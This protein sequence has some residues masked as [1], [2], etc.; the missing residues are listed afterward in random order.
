MNFETVSGTALE[1]TIRVSKPI[2]DAVDQIGQ[3]S[4]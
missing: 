1:K 2:E 3:I 4:S